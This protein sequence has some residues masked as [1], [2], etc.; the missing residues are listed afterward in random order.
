[1]TEQARIVVTVTPEGA[2]RAETKGVLGDRCLEY[3]AVLEDLL[4]ART[5]ES[6]YTADHQRTDAPVSNR[7]EDRDV[8]RA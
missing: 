8:E 2:V 5:V 6:A 3:I 7:E 1:M 4:E